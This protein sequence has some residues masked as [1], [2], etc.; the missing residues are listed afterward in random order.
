VA[1]HTI[2][3]CYRCQARHAWL[4]VGFVVCIGGAKEFQPPKEWEHNGTVT[5]FQIEH[6]ER[7]VPGLAVAVSHGGSLLARREA[8][9]CAA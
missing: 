7:T 5:R 3:V 6:G 9:R 8:L 2:E 4:T 1:G